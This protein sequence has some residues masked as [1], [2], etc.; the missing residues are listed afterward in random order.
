MALGRIPQNFIDDLLNRV[1]IVEMINSRVP[2]KKGGKNYSACCP[3][4]DEKTPSFSV[5]PDKQFYYCFGCGAA[6]NAI[7]FVMD[8]ERMSFPEAVEALADQAGV[9]VPRDTASDARVEKRRKDI[10]TALEQADKYYRTRLRQS[11]KAIEYLKSRGL[12]GKTARDFG[13][14]YAPEG[15]DHL[16]NLLGNDEEHRRLLVESGLLI[17]R[18]DKSGLYD[19][20]RDRVMFP[21]RDI[22]GRTI[23]FG[24][25]VFGDEKPKYLNSPETPIFHKSRELYGLF[26]AIKSERHLKRLIVVEGY[27]DVVALAQFGIRN[28]VATLGTSV[29]PTHIE[30]MF[31]HVNDIVFCFDG[32]DAGRKA[33]ARALEATLPT[34][35]DGRR[36]SFLFLPEGE[37]PDTV[38]QRE[39][40]KSFLKLVEEATPLS[41]FLVQLAGQ[42]CDLQTED[43][44]ARLSHALKPWLA[45]LPKGFFRNLMI[46]RLSELTD[47]PTTEVNELLAESADINAKPNSSNKPY[48]S[49][50]F[51]A[52]PASD[53]KSRSTEKAK[54]VKN[55]PY[56]KIE[57]TPMRNLVSLL[58]NQPKLA[59]EI[60][61]DQLEALSK[62]DEFR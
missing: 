20:F 11:E 17:E 50:G 57:L 35:L 6:G 48:K 28:A 30:K 46:N 38:V 52:T 37:D 15:W 55:R 27:M 4:H 62:Y 43:G 26:E 5:S 25:R 18:D 22:R 42:D 2:L 53:S 39:G 58:L 47:L 13:I 59:V 24:G 40:Q 56:T 33:A 60:R 49:S 14:G 61:A 51:D 36:S 8:F 54:I 29:G 23:A 1:D 34:M 7:G 9:E 21:I 12:E 45:S 44:K 41:D 32:D 16:L 19:R 3:F 31:R 10:Y